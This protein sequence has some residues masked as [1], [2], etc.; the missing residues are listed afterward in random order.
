MLENHRL[1]Q[2]FSLN[3]GAISAQL[4]GGRFMRKL[5]ILIAVLSGT[6]SLLAQD[7]QSLSSFFEGKQVVVKMDMPGSQQG[8]DIYPQRDNSL[9]AKNYGKRMKSF[10]VALRNGDAVMITTVKVKDKLIEFQLGGGGYG[11][12]G[13]DT[14]TS[15]KFTPAP[16]S[17]REKDLENQLSNT[18]D[19]NKKDSI[20]RELDYLRRQRER[21]DQRNRTIAEQAA[22][23]KRMQVDDSRTKGGSRFNLKYDGKV[24]PNITPQDVMAALSQYVAFPAGMTGGTGT[25]GAQAAQGAAAP[26][27]PA[28]PASAPPATINGLQKG[29]HP[30][31][32]RA[33][34]GNPTGSA[35]TDH[36][37]LQVHSETYVQGNSFIHA[38]FVNG[39]LVR[40]SV[41]VH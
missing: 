38:D 21:D 3:S 22:Q 5:V 29:M 9:D 12:F 13:D 23:V 25:G 28:A 4:T 7:A 18:D 24:P 19:Q 33:L 41:D 34:L 10:P 2:S 26:A 16:K 37:G 36:D 17:D 39:V 35:D 30:D 8:I 15:V 1:R 6:V 27:T 14:D 31:Q 32:V 20:Q 40:Y 11:T